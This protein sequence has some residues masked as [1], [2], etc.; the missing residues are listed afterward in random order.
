MS[1]SYEHKVFSGIKLKQ[2]KD[3]LFIQESKLHI[4]IFLINDEKHILQIVIK[5][6][7]NLMKLIVQKVA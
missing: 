5:I 6:E 3:S 4:Y 7:Y 2:H 1:L